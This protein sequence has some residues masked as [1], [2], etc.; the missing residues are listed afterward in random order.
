M[1]AIASTNT[2]QMFYSDIATW[3]NETP[4]S[5]HPKPLFPVSFF[6][7]NLG[8]RRSFPPPEPCPL[9]LE[10]SSNRSTDPENHSDRAFTDLYDAT[11]GE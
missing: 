10:P 6:F 4:T 8:G 7:Q 5:E 2:S 9:T 11:G 3:I 1:A